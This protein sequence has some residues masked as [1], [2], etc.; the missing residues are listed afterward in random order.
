MEPTT[1]PKLFVIQ[2]CVHYGHWPEGQ[3]AYT[4]PIQVRGLKIPELMK[5]TVRIGFRGYSNRPNFIDQPGE[6][7]GDTIML[8][9][10]S[11]NPLFRR[12]MTS[13]EWMV[14]F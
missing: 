9:G 5:S 11:K 13:V 2:R 12:D 10:T 6:L 7:G 8:M 14:W 1:F 4:S 3:F